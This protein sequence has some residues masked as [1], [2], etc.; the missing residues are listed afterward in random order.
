MMEAL[1]NS[2]LQYQRFDAVQFIRDIQLE[3]IRDIQF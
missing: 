3:F 2:K 1:F